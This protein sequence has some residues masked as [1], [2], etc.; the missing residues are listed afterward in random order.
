M[1]IFYLIVFLTILSIGKSQT[2]AEIVNHRIVLDTDSGDFFGKK[3]NAMFFGGSYFVCSQSYNVP[4]SD[5][6]FNNF[7]TKIQ[8]INTEIKAY[9]SLDN[10]N[11]ICV[12]PK[13][14]VRGISSFSGFI[15][16]NFPSGYLS[17]LIGG[18]TTH[19]EVTRVYDPLD[20]ES[21]R[22]FIQFTN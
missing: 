2:E 1:R 12:F 22:G 3:F 7:I 9:K 11:L 15:N 8:N 21:E 16:S 5:V 13:S 19:V 6:D 17:S 14:A 10:K 18:K 4:F 20:K